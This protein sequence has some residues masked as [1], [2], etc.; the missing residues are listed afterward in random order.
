MFPINGLSFTLWYTG[1]L[2]YVPVNSGKC[3]QTSSY[4][5]ITSNHWNYLW[6]QSENLLACRVLPW[7]PRYIY[8][9]IMTVYRWAVGSGQAG[10]FHVAEAL[11]QLFVINPTLTTS[12]HPLAVMTWL[13]N[14]SCEKFDILHVW[15]L[16]ACVQCIPVCSVQPNLQG[17]P[18]AAWEVRHTSWYVTY[19][20]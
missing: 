2:L 4:G 15:S 5:Y 7:L 20:W 18:Q 3:H 6:L 8:N 19:M 17:L 10:Q 16:G 11:T 13:D 9:G 1:N 12:G 14:L